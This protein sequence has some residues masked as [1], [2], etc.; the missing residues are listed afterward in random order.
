VDTVLPDLVNGLSVQGDATPVMDDFHRLGSG[1]S[2]ESVAWFVEHTPSS[3]Q[4]VVATH[5]EPAL[6]LAALRA[7]GELLELRAEELGF[8]GDE[9]ELLLNDRLDLELSRDDVDG[10]VERTEGWPAGLYL[11]ALSLRGIQDRHAFVSN[12]GGT[13]RHLVDVLVDEVLESHDP[14][15]QTL[16][17]RCSVLR[18]QSE[19]LCDALLDR[20]SK[21]LTLSCSRGPATGETDSNGRPL[22]TILGCQRKRVTSTSSPSLCRLWLGPA[23]EPV[24]TPVTASTSRR[25]QRGRSANRDPRGTD[26][27]DSRLGSPPRRTRR[28]HAAV[29]VR[30]EV[31]PSP[32]RIVA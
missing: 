10:L 1:P 22:L 17:L 31:P 4:L 29:R 20:D 18:R 3:F 2:R 19:P 14:A 27:R 15:L 16:I 24:K 5:S 6:P 28:R 9:A 32:A 23:G 25:P 12:F 11:A 13:S 21:F 7:H 30:G 26:I 8:T